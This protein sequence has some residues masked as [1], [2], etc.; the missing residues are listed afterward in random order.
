MCYMNEAEGPIVYTI[1]KI[2]IIYKSITQQEDEPPEEVLENA[3][4][5]FI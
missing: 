5:P 2:N 3:L 4:K 1:F